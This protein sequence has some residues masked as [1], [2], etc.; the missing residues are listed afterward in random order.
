M[1][2]AML[3]P[4]WKR[5]LM[6]EGSRLT[7]RGDEDQDLVAFEEVWTRPVHIVPAAL[8]VRV[9]CSRKGPYKAV[10]RPSTRPIVLSMINGSYCR[11][12]RRL[13]NFRTRRVEIRCVFDPP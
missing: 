4:V 3:P 12:R 13:N 6:A 5:A 11:R 9:Q 10:E 8:L 1:G 2:Q 7:I